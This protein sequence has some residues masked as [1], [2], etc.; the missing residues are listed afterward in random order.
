[1]VIYD[2]LG[3]LVTKYWLVD[4]VYEEN[5][6]RAVFNI[7]TCGRRINNKV[8]KNQYRVIWRELATEMDNRADTHCSGDNFQH[9]NISEYC[10][11]KLFCIFWE[12]YRH[13]EILQNEWYW[14]KVFSKTMGIST[15][16]HFSCWCP[17][18]NLVLIFCNLLI[19]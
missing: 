19:T 15:I 17:T 11:I 6:K 5:V 13:S 16:V 7:N 1:M 12:E 18:N 8:H 4:L 10:Y 3:N 14:S 9:I 2:H